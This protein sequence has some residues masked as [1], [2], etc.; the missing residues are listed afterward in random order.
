MA[1]YLALYARLHPR[2]WAPFATLD[3]EVLA[4]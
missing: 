2:L 4:C 3:R 1:N